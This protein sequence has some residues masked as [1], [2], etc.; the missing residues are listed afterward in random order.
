MIGLVQLGSYARADRYVYIPLIGIFVA[1]AWALVEFARRR[2][3]ERPALAIAGF[4]VAYFL[5]LGWIQVHFWH[6][7]VLLWENAVKVTYANPIAYANLGLA[8]M[9]TEKEKAEQYL[10]R[11]V[12]LAP[13]LQPGHMA[14]G[15]LR[16]QM[17]DIPGAAEQLEETLRLGPETVEA[18]IAHVNLGLI[19]ADR[20]KLDE[21]AEHFSAA[22]RINPDI[23]D[24]QCGMGMYLSRRGKPEQGDVHFK[25][26][27]ELEPDNAQTYLT[28]GT[29]RLEQDRHA[30]ATELFN[31]ALRLNAELAT[32]QLWKVGMAFQGI[33]KPAQAAVCLRL[34]E[35]R[36]KQYGK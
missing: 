4:A 10:Q 22:L 14:L 27:I 18:Q 7:S 3:A 2:Q 21:A 16:M 1:L 26:A 11:S 25:K 35:D 36:A 34:I 8:L 29:T 15:L 20:G 24:A 30:E 28:V 19:S 5:I 9:S 12:A 31:T 33:G 23:V 32:Q 13:H 17:G 6:N